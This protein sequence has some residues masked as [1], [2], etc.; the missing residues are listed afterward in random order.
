MVPAASEFAGWKTGYGEGCGCGAKCEGRRGP[1][2]GGGGAS[3]GAGDGEPRIATD[4]GVDAWASRDLAYAGTSFGGNVDR[5]SDV[6]LGLAYTDGRSDQELTYSGKCC[7]V[8]SLEFVPEVANVVPGWVYTHTQV[9]F[10]VR[11]DYEL[12]DT[13][14][15]NE[16]GAK[17]SE[18]WWEIK[19]DAGAPEKYDKWDPSEWNNASV[20][21]SVGRDIAGDFATK[22]ADDFA[23]KKTASYGPA[24]GVHAHE[25]TPNLDAPWWRTVNSTLLI[26]YE[27]KSGCGPTCCLLILVDYATQPI[28]VQTRGPICGAGCKKPDVSRVGGGRGVV[29]AYPGDSYGDAASPLI[30][31]DGLGAPLVDSMFMLANMFGPVVQAKFRLE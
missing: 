13:Q 20:D 27:V 28:T 12:V 18:E 31:I 21:N 3:E 2:C 5:G 23:G 25:D 10:Y 29:V 15:E 24:G 17:C 16:Y 9:N 8:K 4:A 26:Y 7:R 11:V 30:I 1:T 6:G 14:N 19:S 22:Q